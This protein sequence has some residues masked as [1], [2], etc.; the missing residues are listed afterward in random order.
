MACSNILEIAAD[1]PVRQASWVISKLSVKEH[2]HKRRMA[3]HA[4]SQLLYL[5]V[6]MLIVDSEYARYILSIHTAGLCYKQ[7]LNS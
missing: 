2:V 1:S 6:I 3:R 4:I 5:Q 7:P